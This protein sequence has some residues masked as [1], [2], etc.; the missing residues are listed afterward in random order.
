MFAKLFEKIKLD[1]TSTA[2]SAHL[3]AIVENDKNKKSFLCSQIISAMH[4]KSRLDYFGVEYVLCYE[5]TA[6]KGL[7]ISNMASY[8]LNGYKIAD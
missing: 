3:T 5:V 8:I 6:E 4:L 2:E 7:I 1:L